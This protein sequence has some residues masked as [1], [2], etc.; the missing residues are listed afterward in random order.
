MLLWEIT[1]NFLLISQQLLEMQKEQ[2]LE[3]QTW[4]IF[5][6]WCFAIASQLQLSKHVRAGE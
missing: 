4:L 5:Y 2:N 6:T 1:H 3:Q